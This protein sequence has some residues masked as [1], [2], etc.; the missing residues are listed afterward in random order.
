M[1][2]KKFFEDFRGVWVGGPAA[3]LPAS[4]RGE[5]YVKIKVS[6]DSDRFAL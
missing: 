5:G 2:G 3:F 6:Q 1:I 4:Q